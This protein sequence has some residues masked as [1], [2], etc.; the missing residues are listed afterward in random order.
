MS[1]NKKEPKSE[2]ETEEVKT[3]EDE[4]VEEEAKEKSEEIKEEKVEEKKEKLEEE[5]VEEKFYTVP[6]GRACLS[7]R[8][9][10]TPKAVRILRDFIQRH[11]KPESIIISNEVNEK[12]WSRS[13]EKPPRKIRVRATKD[14]EGVVTVHLA[15]EG[16]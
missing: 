5:F 2:V 7:P 15:A 9:K 10:R 8:P 6:L 14:K 11:M 12:L 3:K 1:T 16:D 4:G 13:I